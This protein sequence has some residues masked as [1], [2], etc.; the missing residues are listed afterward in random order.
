MNNTNQSSEVKT[1]NLTLSSALSWILGII[2]GI[3]AISMVGSQPF[4]GLIVLIAAIIVFPPTYKVIEGKLHLSLSRG[5]KITSVLILLIIAGTLMPNVPRLA[6]TSTNLSVVEKNI[7]PE[8]TPMI[9]VTATKLSEDY[10]ANEISA[11]AKY[12][13]KTVE[14]SGVV[15][16]I[17]KDIL[18]TPYIVLKTSQ[19]AVM[20]SVQ[21]MFSKED[22]SKL[23]NVS[24]E[25]SIVLTGEVSG[26]MGNI[27]VNSCQI[28]K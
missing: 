14:I 6:P 2:F 19:Y 26:K 25:Q 11:D 20:D 24:K 8:P 28:S 16:S 17:G 5:L 12:K 3:T 18:S 4:A 23:M 1:K 9:K 7:Q 27:L 22:E 15:G 21:C 10:K 13:G